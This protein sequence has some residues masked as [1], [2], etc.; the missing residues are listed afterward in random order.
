MKLRIKT[1][2]ST[3]IKIQ[4][5]SHVIDGITEKNTHVCKYDPGKLSVNLT[6]LLFV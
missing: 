6:L 3:A 4:E 1:F 5:G 2:K